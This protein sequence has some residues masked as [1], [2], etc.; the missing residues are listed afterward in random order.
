MKTP[1]YLRFVKL[2]NMQKSFT[3][4]SRS[5]HLFSLI[6][7]SLL[8]LVTSCTVQKRIYRSG[9]YFDWKKVKTYSDFQT[10]SQ[11][12]ET[13]EASTLNEDVCTTTLLPNESSITPNSAL[14]EKIRQDAPYVNDTPD[15]TDCDVIILENGTE[16]KAKIKDIGTNEITYTKCE[17]GDNTL[18]SVRI[19]DVSQVKIHNNPKESNSTRRLKKNNS[20]K[21]EPFSLAS[22]LCSLTIFLFPLGGLL[23]VIFGGISLKR[24]KKD[25]DD[26]KLKVLAIVGL[27]LG[28]IQI[29]L[30]IAGIIILMFFW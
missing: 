1:L 20:R 28:I 16:I 3:H 22:L 2:K 23:G 29:T 12:I 15:S 27:I 19:D 9:Y 11:S 6:I 30:V 8:I 24:F 5:L 10:N 14:I 4:S 7:C 26:Y 21:I 18:L 13:E 17:G 25:P